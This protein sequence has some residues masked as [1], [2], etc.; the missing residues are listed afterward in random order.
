MTTRVFVAVFL[1]LVVFSTLGA[2]AAIVA[3]NDDSGP[4]TTIVGTTTVG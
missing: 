2:I 4:T 3:T 1:A